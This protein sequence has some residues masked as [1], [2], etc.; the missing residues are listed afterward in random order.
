M[1]AHPHPDTVSEPVPVP[2]S[3][4]QLQTN[5]QPQTKP[6]K[7][8]A[9]VSAPAPAAVA[10]VLECDDHAACAGG[11]CVHS[12][13]NTA[14][15]LG[16]LLL[17]GNKL[18][19]RSRSS[20]RSQTAPSQDPAPAPA[21]T[22]VNTTPRRE[23]VLAPGHTH[24]IGFQCTTST[25]T[26]P[27]AGS[28]SGSNSDSNSDS[29]SDSNSNSGSDSDS[30]SDASM[31]MD[32]ND[33]S[34]VQRSRYERRNCIGLPFFTARFALDEARHTYGV[35][36]GAFAGDRSKTDYVKYAR[37][38]LQARYVPDH[39]ALVGLLYALVRA[40]AHGQPGAAN[41]ALVAIFVFLWDSSSSA[42]GP[43]V[44]PD[45]VAKY[46]PFGH[47]A[48]FWAA[49]WATCVTEG[50][51]TFDDD[52]NSIV[53][54]VAR[55]RPDT[56]AKTVATAHAIV[57][58][59]AAML[60]IRNR[61]GL[62]RPGSNSG[63]GSGSGSATTA[64]TATTTT[65][66]AAVRTQVL[67][68]ADLTDGLAPESDLAPVFTRLQQHLEPHM[69]MDC[70]FEVEVTPGCS[71]DTVSLLKPA[72]QASVQCFVDKLDALT[73]FVRQHGQGIDHGV[74]V[75]VDGVAV[76]VVVTEAVAVAEPVPTS[77]LLDDAR[78]PYSAYSP[79]SPDSLPYNPDS[80]AYEPTSPTY[81]D[82]SYEPAC[83]PM[84]SATSP[85][86][87][88]SD[89]DD[90]VE[91]VLEREPA[92]APAP[93]PA[94]LATVV[95]LAAEVAVVVALAPAPAS[96]SAPAVAI[97]EAVSLQQP[98]PQPKA[99]VRRLRK[100]KSVHAPESSSVQSTASTRMTRSK[101][102]KRPASSSA[103]EDEVVAEAETN[104][105]PRVRARV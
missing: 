26:R 16:S 62:Q 76:A 102:A 104:T 103:D 18:H 93:A 95:E 63:S 100:T 30:D 73:S 86:Y 36:E 56:L 50:P 65:A 59:D 1:S 89:D 38:I 19:Q 80:P 21:T 85:P 43:V 28:D 10:Y 77:P 54:Y 84:Y 37:C 17:E 81:E 70:V 94:Q 72:M 27:D 91:R 12:P 55:V 60:A 101:A 25:S 42:S 41:A 8:K 66:A 47:R 52:D 31:T 9:K 51:I 96:A 35:G 67:T 83:S 82:M 14:A 49:L 99:S 61:N 53:T 15:T 64:T 40:L 71:L 46:V 32:V 6:Q 3:S 58:V 97:E 20:R 57:V 88:P 75:D 39:D 29:D 11:P 24:A 5:P 90:D 69:D 68:V 105:K 87:A 22:F 98:Q 44:V 45:V 23:L 74:D 79:G 13:L 78:S 92:L 33:M 7:A 4:P 34:D 2:Q 48:A